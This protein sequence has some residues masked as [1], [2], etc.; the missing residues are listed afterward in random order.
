MLLSGK[1]GT[2]NSRT[3]RSVSSAWSTTCI[4]RVSIFVAFRLERRRCKAFLS[5]HRRRSVTVGSSKH[6]CGR[7]YRQVGLSA[8]RPKR[9]WMCRL[10]SL[11]SFGFIY[12]SELCT[13]FESSLKLLSSEGARRLYGS[14]RRRPLALFQA[15]TYA[16]RKRTR[17]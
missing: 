17:P 6:T 12:A 8:G 15:Y 3:E 5:P 13:D 1:Q 4:S 11:H 14:L 7:L 9:T 10:Y 16:R 2:T